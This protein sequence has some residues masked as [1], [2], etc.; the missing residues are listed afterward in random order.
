M[1]NLSLGND[2]EITIDRLAEKINERF[3]RADPAIKKQIVDFAH[4]FYATAPLE[5]LSSKRIDDLYSAT[6]AL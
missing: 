4:Y 2:Y 3:D 1:V 6:V 5:E